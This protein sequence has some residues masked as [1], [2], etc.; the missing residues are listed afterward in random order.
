MEG[1][2]PNEAAAQVVPSGRHIKS[3][4]QVV[5]SILHAPIAVAYGPPSSGDSR[6]GGHECD[7]RPTGACLCKRANA[8]AWR[9]RPQEAVPVSKLES[10]ATHQRLNWLKRS[11]SQDRGWRQDCFWNWPAIAERRVRPDG[12][13][14]LTPALNEDLGFA[15]CVEDLTV[16]LLISELAIKALIVSI[17][18]W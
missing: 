4:H 6:L 16:K 7:I 3:S 8:P 11:V 17:L 9:G 18:P 10:G 15:W 1:S 14:V 13:V 12:I 2:T 5:T